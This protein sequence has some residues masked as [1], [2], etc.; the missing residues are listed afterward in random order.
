MDALKKTKNSYLALFDQKI[1]ELK[2]CGRVYECQW[3]QCV[4][5]LGGANFDF[6][7]CQPMGGKCA[8]NLGECIKWESQCEKR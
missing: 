7:R 1:D 5:N 8:D 2:R 4:Y 3:E 6:D